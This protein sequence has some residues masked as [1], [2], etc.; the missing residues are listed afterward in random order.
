EKI[1]YPAGAGNYDGTNTGLLSGEYLEVVA[2]F[3]DRFTGETITNPQYAGEYEIVCAGIIIRNAGGAK[4]EGGENNYTFE[5]A[6]SGTLTIEGSIVTVTLKTLKKYYDGTA[7]TFTGAD[8]EVSYKYGTAEGEKTE[9]PAGYT[10]Q[11]VKGCATDGANVQSIDNT[12]EFAVYR[13]NEPSGEYVVQYEKDAEGSKLIIQARPVNIKTDGGAKEYDG[14]ELTA[15]YGYAD[16]NVYGLL[17]GHTFKVLSQAK[18]TDVGEI[19]NN[20]VFAVMDG[21]TDVTGNYDIKITDCGKLV[22]TACEITVTLGN[23][24][25]VYGAQIGKPAITTDKALIKGTLSVGTYIAAKGDESKTA[26]TIERDKN[27]YVLLNKGTYAIVAD[28]N[29]VSVAGGKASNYKFTFNDG[30]LTVS[31]RK[32]SVV[33]NDNKKAYDGTML[34]VGGYKTYL[35]GN[36]N[37]AGLIGGDKLTVD[38]AELAAKGIVNVNDEMSNQFAF[39]LPNGNY[40]IAEVKYGTL[41]ITPRS[42]TVKTGSVGVDETVVYDGNEHFNAVGTV[43]SGTL[44]EGHRLVADETTVLKLINATAGKANT[45]KFKVFDGATDVTENYS[46]VYDNGTII[47]VPAKLTVTINA[48]ADKKVSFEYGDGTIAQ[49]MKTYTAVCLVG[50]DTLTVAIGYDCGEL[51]VAVGNYTAYLDK[52]NCV[53]TTN[54][55]TGIE[56]GIVNY[57]VECEDV[58]FEITRKKVTLTFG[59][60][61]EKVYD[62]NLYT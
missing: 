42:I 7:L 8:G 4:I 37:L 58:D 19:D 56:N 2:A 23:L 27:G 39:A 17:S 24:N 48:T 3:K 46:I 33:T 62:G 50:T 9:L 32:I 14:E 44:A 38:E 49:R 57:E 45:T 59:G 22:V 52:D 47:I 6:Q 16:G 15:G 12:A 26:I 43:T 28:K 11:M 41:K 1:E 53:V 30:T 35:Y 13:G 54:N 61:V 60:N 18:I 29:S 5:D 51:P 20:Y 40:E 34:N 31:A 21:T 10:L 36:K 55:G 25:T